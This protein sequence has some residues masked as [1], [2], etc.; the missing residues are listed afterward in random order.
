MIS[1]NRHGVSRQQG[2]SAHWRRRGD[3]RRIT[4]VTTDPGRPLLRVESAG[5]PFE[6]GIAARVAPS[7]LMAFLK[8]SFPELLVEEQPLSSP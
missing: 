1:V 6:A 5:R 2:Q 8:R 7:E 3:I 4:V